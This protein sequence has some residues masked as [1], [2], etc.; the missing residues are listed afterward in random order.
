[1]EFALQIADYETAWQREAEE[2]ERD[3]E[4]AFDREIFPEE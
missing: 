3:K 4:E 2:I 1:M